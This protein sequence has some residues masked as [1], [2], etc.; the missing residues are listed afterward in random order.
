MPFF[1]TDS[2][3]CFAMPIFQYLS[4]IVYTLHGCL[5]PICTLLYPL[6]VPTC[7]D[8]QM[9]SICSPNLPPTCTDQAGQ[10][11]PCRPGCACPTGMVLREEDGECVEPHFCEGRVLGSL[12]VTHLRKCVKFVFQHLEWFY[13]I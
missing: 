9:Y 6:I 8:G 7:P 11:E 5:T 2:M 13:C 10:S 3:L 1:F 4:F 12:H